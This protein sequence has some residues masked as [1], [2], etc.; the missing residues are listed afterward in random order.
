ML[1]NE[2]ADS[3]LTGGVDDAVPIVILEDVTAEHAGPERALGMQL[4]RVEND[5]LTHYVHEI[6]TIRGSATA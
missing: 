5:H 3:P 2:R 4:G 1:G 6:D